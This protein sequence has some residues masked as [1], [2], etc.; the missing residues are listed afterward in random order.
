MLVGL[1]PKP[2]YTKERSQ[3]MDT[4]ITA[5]KAPQ[6]RRRNVQMVVRM[7]PDEREFIMA[8]V[9]ASGLNNFNLF[10][11]TMLIRGE[12]KNVDLKHY[13][14]L[15]KEVSRIGTNI[16]QIA[17]FANSNGSIYASEVEDLQRRMEDIWQLLKSNLSALQSKKL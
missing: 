4:Q 3:H 9:K 15:A 11:L 7:T 2:A 6:R 10:A 1:P 14:E 13:H 17:R 8:K 12:I 16:N 5:Q